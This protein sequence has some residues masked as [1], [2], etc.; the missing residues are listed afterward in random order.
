M[1]WPISQS[2]VGRRIGHYIGRVSVESQSIYRPI[3]RTVCRT[4]VDSV[5][6]WPIYQSIFPYKTQKNQQNNSTQQCRGL[7]GLTCQ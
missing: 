7:K 2:S 3:C 1:Y 5:R 4:T 6:Y